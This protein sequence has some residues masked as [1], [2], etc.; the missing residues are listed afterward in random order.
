MYHDIYDYAHNI[1]W[2]LRIHTI[3]KANTISFKEK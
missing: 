2:F 1:H 3:R